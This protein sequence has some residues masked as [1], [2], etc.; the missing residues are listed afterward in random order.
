MK[1]QIEKVNTLTQRF[2][3]G[4]KPFSKTTPPLQNLHNVLS[5]TRRLQHTC[6]ASSFRITVTIQWQLT[7]PTIHSFHSTTRN[8]KK[9]LYHALSFLGKFPKNNRI[10][11]FYR[12]LKKQ[13]TCT[14]ILQK[15]VQYSMINCHMSSPVIKT[16]RDCTY[17]S[18]ESIMT[19][20]T[21]IS[22]HT[23]QDADTYKWTDTSTCQLDMYT[24]I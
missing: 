6:N 3:N 19:I 17:T 21:M 10:R 13:E 9:C 5:S 11:V 23:I 7:I 8:P 22:L 12:S 4:E 24:H 2:V 1:K 18:Y 16:S 14:P 20:S 15:Y